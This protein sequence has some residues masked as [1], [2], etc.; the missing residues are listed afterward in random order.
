MIIASLLSLIQAANI[1]DAV[2]AACRNSALFLLVAVVKSLSLRMDFSRWLQKAMVIAGIAVAWFA[3]DAVLGGKGIAWINMAINGGA[4]QEGEKG[5]FFS[6]MTG[7]RPGSLFQYPNTAAALLMT[8]W[9]IAIYRQIY[10]SNTKRS[11]KLEHFFCRRLF[12][13]FFSVCPDHK[14]RH[15]L[16]RRFIFS[17]I[18]DLAAQGKMSEGYLALYCQYCTGNSDG[19]VFFFRRVP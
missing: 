14:P 13:D 5:F 9:F 15:V 17:V 19:P 4:L 18:H 1:Y 6:M 12:P 10:I 7:D 8:A 3:L 2:Y 11:I 16:N